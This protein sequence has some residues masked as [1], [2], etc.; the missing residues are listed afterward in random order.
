VYTYLHNETRGLMILHLITRIIIDYLTSL[1]QQSMLSVPISRLGDKL[2][3][4]I[5]LYLLIPLD[6]E[7]LAIPIFTDIRK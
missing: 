6:L 3:L 4:W 7:V 5:S 2:D 1:E